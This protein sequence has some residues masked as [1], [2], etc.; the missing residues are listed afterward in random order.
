MR[1]SRDRLREWTR[2]PAEPIR[3]ALR[4]RWEDRAQGRRD[5]RAGLPAVDGDGDTPW[6]RALRKLTEDAM[7]AELIVHEQVVAELTDLRGTAAAPLDA[8]HDRLLRAEAWSAE[9][10][11]EP[12]LDLR[13]LADDRHPAHLARNRRLAESL[14]VRDSAAR[15]L[16]EVR[17][18]VGDTAHLVASLDREIDRAVEVARLRVARLH[19]HGCRRIAAYWQHVVRRHPDGAQLNARVTPREP[20]P[21]GVGGR[22]E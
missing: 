8:L 19:A 13:R 15:G 20:E 16:F 10:D 1:T 18:Q 21:A 12:D 5:G 4:H 3:Y 9:A 7:A 11:K 6:L 17:R 14:V 22:P 2:P